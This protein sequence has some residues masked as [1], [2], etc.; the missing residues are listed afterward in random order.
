VSSEP[1]AAHAFIIGLGAIYVLSIKGLLPSWA[2][3]HLTIGLLTAAAILSLEF[4]RTPLPSFLRFASEIAKFSFSLYAIHYPILAL[5]NVVAS[6]NHTDFTFASFGLNVIFMLCCLSISFIFYLL[7]ESHTHAVRTLVRN[8]T[9]RGV[10]ASQ[11]L[12]PVIIFGFAIPRQATTE[13]H[14]KPVPEHSRGSLGK[15]MSSR[16]WAVVGTR[17][18]ACLKHRRNC[19]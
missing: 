2:A 9:R 12:R 16:S 11:G 14:G 10:I 5:L 15:S 6:S 18:P 13:D 19:N 1:G 8:I 7:F 4:T 17:M 3:Y